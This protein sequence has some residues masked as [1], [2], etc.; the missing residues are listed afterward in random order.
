MK[1]KHLPKRTIERVIANVPDW[2]GE[3]HSRAQSHVPMDGVTEAAL[4]EAMVSGEDLQMVRRSVE[5]FGYMRN[6][7]YGSMN[8][9]IVG[10]PGTSFKLRI[11]VPRKCSWLLPAYLWSNDVSAASL[12]DAFVPLLQPV[13]EQLDPLRHSFLAARDGYH[14]L[15]KLCNDDLSRMYFLWPVLGTLAKNRDA[16]LSALPKPRAVPGVSP[17]LRDKLNE[18][19][20][21]INITMMMPEPVTYSADILS[22]SLV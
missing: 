11:V 14:A 2:L 4:C 5:L 8:T 22:V 17:E 9:T 15:R 16:D 13:V 1:T 18:G 20:A 12:P 7:Y 6:S 3:L 19:T 10:F 21:F